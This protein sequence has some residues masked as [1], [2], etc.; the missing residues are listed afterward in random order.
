MSLYFLWFYVWEHPKAQPAVVLFLKHLRSRGHSLKSHLTDWES[1]E[2][3][4][5]LLG[6]RRVTYPLHHSDSLIKHPYLL[7]L[8]LF[9]A[10]ISILF[11]I[12]KNFYNPLEI[13]SLSLI[14]FQI[15]SKSDVQFDAMVFIWS[16]R[17][18][19]GS[20]PTLDF[21]DVIF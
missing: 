16:I 11:I 13:I 5:G 9:F 12:S 14:F 6:T 3:N 17:N 8:V 4:S 21:P 19:G 15:L 10:A 7:I 1:Q 20:Q 2:S 18:S